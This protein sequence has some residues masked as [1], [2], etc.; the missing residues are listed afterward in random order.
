MGFNIPGIA[1]FLVK[2]KQ[3]YW[4]GYFNDRM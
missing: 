1:E 2:S 3:Y 4:L